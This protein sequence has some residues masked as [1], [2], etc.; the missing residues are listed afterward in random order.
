MAT[1]TVPLAPA[2][3]L[4]WVTLPEELAANLWKVRFDP[5][6]PDPVDVAVASTPINFWITVAEVVKDAVLAA[7]AVPAEF[8]AEQR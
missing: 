1:L 2:L 6:P 5:T 8:V 3:T 7:Q 4:I